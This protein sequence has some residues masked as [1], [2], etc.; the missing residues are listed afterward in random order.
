MSMTFVTVSVDG[1][2]L[3]FNGF[4]NPKGKVMC[5]TDYIELPKG[6]IAKLIGREL[7][8]DDEPVELK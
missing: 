5:V 8:W 6:T 1:E 7:T 4:V 2:E 3:I